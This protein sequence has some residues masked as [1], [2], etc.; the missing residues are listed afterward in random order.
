[1]AEESKKGNIILKLF[2]YFIYCFI[3]VIGTIFIVLLDINSIV[4]SSLVSILVG[5]FTVIIND[6]N[7]LSWA[8]FCG[9]FAG[10]TSPFILGLNSGNLSSNFFLSVLLLAVI[11]S[12]IYSFSEFVSYKF[13]KIS[14]DGYGG[15]LGTIAFISV[16][17]YILIMKFGLN[18]SI[19]IFH[20]EKLFNSNLDYFIL[21]VVLSSIIAS[22]ISMEIKTTVSSLNENYK[23]ITVATTGLIGGILIT[24]IPGFGLDYGLAWY[25]GAFVG[26]SSYYVLML[27]R[28]F[29]VSGLLSGVY[30]L[31]T[32]NMFV[33]VGGK[34]GF[35]SFLS[36]LSMKFLSSIYGF[37]K[38][39]IKPP[40]D[41]LNNLESGEII[42]QRVDDDYAEKL[43]ES[44]L[45][46]KDKI[47]INSDIGNF[48]IGEKIDIKE[49]EEE[50]KK[51]IYYFELLS[52]KEQ[53]FIK[54]IN[55]LGINKWCYLQ[56]DKEEFNIFSYQGIEDNTLYNTRYKINSKFID[57]LNS[58]RRIIVFSK[59]GMNQ[60]IFIN[61]IDKNDLE[62]I[63]L[64]MIVPVFK[65]KILIGMFFIFDRKDFE[66]SKRD[67]YRIFD[68]YS[69]NL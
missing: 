69:K 3:G 64:F 34:L 62:D 49:Y 11:T 28:H 6:E 53:N 10:M 48:V 66:Y 21:F 8:T 1:M 9:S 61:K 56:R 35:I 20:N 52:K 41:M 38:R 67:Y 43:V 39:S 4:A 50:K 22:L 23:V 24:K 27:K 15:R 63:S 32:K 42:D 47:N 33:G 25:T 65:D 17:L 44:L 57:V 19:D 29:F 68:F 40:E 51:N 36:V 54:F 31:L 30:F 58:E 18:K 13:P 16:I 55:S 45:K 26:M 5:F 7:H 60:S 12:M 2:L 59:K 37:I 14:F 46:A